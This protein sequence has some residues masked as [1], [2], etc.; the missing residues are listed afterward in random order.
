MPLPNK[1]YFCVKE[2]VER[3]STKKR[4]VHYYIENNLLKTHVWLSHVSVSADVDYYDIEQDGDSFSVI[5]DTKTISGLYPLR[6][7]D[8]HILF[9]K[10][11]ATIRFMKLC[12]ESGYYRNN[13]DQGVTITLDDIVIL[14]EECLRF[15]QEHNI[16]TLDSPSITDQQQTYSHCKFAIVFAQDTKNKQ[17]LFPENIT[18]GKS[19]YH[20]VSKLIVLFRKARKD[21]LEKDSYEYLS[22]KS[23]AK[24]LNM[25]E[26]SIYKG[27]KRLRKELS[28]QFRDKTGFYVEE[29]SKYLP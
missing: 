26:S 9:R 14:R 15:E 21:E 1:K 13:D 8:S 7:D 23:L 11:R 24:D 10:G 6:A 3:W 12:N 4:D 25:E 17:I 27:I 16:S 29:K 2:V 20:I 22:T 19:Y 5:E 18:L 28:D